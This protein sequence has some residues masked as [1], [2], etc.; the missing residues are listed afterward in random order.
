MCGAALLCVFAHGEPYRVARRCPQPCP[1]SGEQPRPSPL[2]ADKKAKPRRLLPKARSAA[3]RRIR[4]G[5]RK[6]NDRALRSGCLQLSRASSL[7]PRG[8]R[9]QQKF[10]AASMRR[11]MNARGQ[12]AL[13]QGGR[14]LSQIVRFNRRKCVPNCERLP[15]V[16][17]AGRYGNGEI[18]ANTIQVSACASTMSRNRPH[19]IGL[20]FFDPVEIGCNA[21]GND[22]PLQ[23]VWC[24][25][26]GKDF[27][28]SHRRESR[29][30]ES[31]VEST[32]K[33]TVKCTVAVRWM[34]GEMTVKWTNSDGEEFSSLSRPAS[35]RN[36]CRVRAIPGGAL[37]RRSGRW[38]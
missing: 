3:H 35:G 21:A 17:S 26:E 14:S 30:R 36:C 2:G 34:H 24:A 32:V 23:P 10:A 15:R 7:T 4:A 12:S 27:A 28:L 38:F 8:H 37:C 25:L 5:L 11:C 29:R 22:V 33:L 6:E 31:T 18:K 1:E 9:R 16:R 13:K 19:S 20:M